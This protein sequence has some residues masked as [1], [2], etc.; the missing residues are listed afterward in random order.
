GAS[1]LGTS[2]FSSGVLI[3]RTPPTVTIT[4]GPGNGSFIR[5]QT[6]IFT[7]TGSDA[8][9]GAIEFAYR[10]D[11]A[12]YGPFSTVPSARLSPLIE[13]SHQ[14]DVKARDAVGNESVQTCAFN[15]T[16]LVAWWPAEGSA[17]DVWAG[18]DGS[19]ALG[20]TF[21]PGKVGQAFSFNG[22]AAISVPD[23][24]A[25]DFAPNHPLTLEAWAMRTGTAT[26]GHILGKR[27]G[28]DSSNLSYQLGY[29]SRGVGIA[30][31]ADDLG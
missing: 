28:C 29:D 19:V 27:L 3:D 12:A 14:F 4:R 30:A 23:S 26:G 10:L 24:P 18:H 31:S 8:G 20:V 17:G 5:S 7:W 9:G 22:T 15:T 1:Y 25:L 11:G 6:A 13:G 2:A 21:A 16:G